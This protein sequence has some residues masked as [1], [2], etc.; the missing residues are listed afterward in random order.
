VVGVIGIAI[1]RYLAVNAL[2]MSAFLCFQYQVCGSF[3][4]V[5]NRR[6]ADQMACKDFEKVFSAR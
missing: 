2:A 1:T 5:S 6:G 4:Q 3:S